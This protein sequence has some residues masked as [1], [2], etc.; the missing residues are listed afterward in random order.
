LNATAF[1]SKL[2]QCAAPLFVT[3]VNADQVARTEEFHAAACCF[4]LLL[5]GKRS[6]SHWRMKW[7]LV[8][9]VCEALV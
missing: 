8:S 1:P 2:F 9:V 3:F 4:L 5:C 7:F 6:A